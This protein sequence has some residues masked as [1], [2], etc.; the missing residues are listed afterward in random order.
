MEQIEGLIQRMERAQKV[1]MP[2]FGVETP[3]TFALTDDYVFQE[4]PEL[5]PILMR[6]AQDIEMRIA[7]ERFASVIAKHPNGFE[8]FGHVMEEPILDFDIGILDFI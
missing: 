5:R 7:N 8:E 6:A 3:M 2:V 1:L 4:H